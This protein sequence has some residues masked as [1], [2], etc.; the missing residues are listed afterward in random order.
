VSLSALLTFS[1]PKALPVTIAHEAWTLMSS[2]SQTLFDGGLLDA[3]LQAAKANYDQGVATYRQTVLTA[4]QQVEDE[5]ATVRLYAQELKPLGVAVK[6]AHEAIGFYMNQYRVGTVA[7]TAVVTA[8][9][10]LLT[11]IK[12][13]LTARQNLFVAAVT[14]IGALGSGWDASTLPAIDYLSAIKEPPLPVPVSALPA[15]VTDPNAQ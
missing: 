2:A 5:L 15:T 9:S 3:Q 1:G 12:Q 10:T 13:E 11:N 7:F 8:Q 14:L 6:E 4:F